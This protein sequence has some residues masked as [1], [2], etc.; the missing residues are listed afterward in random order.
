MAIHSLRS[1]AFAAAGVATRQH[2][3]RAEQLQADGAG[4]L[5][6]HLLHVELERVDEPPHA[7]PSPLPPPPP[8][9]SFFFFEFVIS[10][11]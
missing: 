6:L 11:G 7:L 2:R 5:Q 8:L 10:H 9:R 1:G 3:R 4:E